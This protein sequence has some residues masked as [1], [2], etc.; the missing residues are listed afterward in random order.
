MLLALL[1]LLPA[2]VYE[3][4]EGGWLEWILERGPLLDKVVHAVLFGVLAWLAFRSFDALGLSRTGLLAALVASAYG[5]ILDLAQSLVPGRATEGLDMIADT[6]G[7]ICGAIMAHSIRLSSSRPLPPGARRR[8]S[9]PED[10]I[11]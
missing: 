4:A 3:G 5:A 10:S 6:V 7:A 9:E 2:D 11:P 1:L 8:G